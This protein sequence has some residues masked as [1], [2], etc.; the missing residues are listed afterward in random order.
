M[1]PH[2]V[3]E[4][5]TELSLEARRNT[6]S[7]R[8]SDQFAAHEGNHMLRLRKFVPWLCGVLA[9]ASLSPAVSTAVYNRIGRSKDSQVPESASVTNTKQTKTDQPNGDYGKLPIYFEPNVGQTDSEV[10]FIVRSSG[11]TTFLTATEA[12][13]S[14][15]VAK[16]RFPIQGGDDEQ[17]GSDMDFGLKAFDPAKLRRM[18]AGQNPQS[19]VASRQSA[20]TMRLVGANRNAQIEG[21][22]RLPG[23]SNYFIGNDPKS[24][25]TNIPHFAKVRYRDVYPGIDLVYYGSGRS[26]EYDLVVEPGGDPKRIELAFEGADEIQLAADGSLLVRVA[27]TKFLQRPP[28]IY[29]LGGKAQMGSS[30]AQRQTNVAGHYVIRDKR[31]IGFE[32]SSYDV[33][34]SLIIDPVIVYSSFLGGSQDEYA[35]G[36]AVDSTGNAYVTGYSSSADFPV[37]PGALQPQRAGNVDAFVGKVNRKGDAL[38]FMTYLGGSSGDYAR[39]MAL[40]AAGNLCLTG[41]AE[42]NNFP[43]TSNA[44]QRTLSGGECVRGNPCSDV[45]VAKLNPDGSSLHYSTYFGGSGDDLAYAIVVEP[46][47]ILTIAGTTS[48][49]VGITGQ[50]FP[51]TVGAYQTN[52]RGELDAFLARFSP[53]GS[54]LVYS[55]LFGGTGSEYAFALATDEV[56]NSYVAGMTS[57]RDLPTTPGA[58]QSSHA[59]PAGEPGGG[60][61]AFVAKLSSNGTALVYSTYLGGIREDAGQSIVVDSLGNAYVGGVTGSPNFPVSS[62]AFQRQYLGS[63]DGFLSK[64]N[65]SG[66]SLVLSTLLGGSNF[67]TIGAIALDPSGRIVATGRSVSVDFP[68]ETVPF[69]QYPGGSFVALLNSVGDQLL[70]SISLG[71][72]LE[73][74]GG[75]IAVHPSGDIYVA[76]RT[77]SVDFPTV[78][79]FQPRPGPAGSG[80]GGDA[81][82]AKVSFNTDLPERLFVPIVLGTSGANGSYFTSELALTNRA[83]QEA[84][85]EFTYTAAIGSGSGTGSDILPRGRQ[86]IVPDALAYLRALGIP[87][88]VS[89]N[90]GGTLSVLIR[91]VP[92]ADLG[93]VVRTT[94]ATGSGRAGLAYGGVSLSQALWGPSYLVGLRQDSQ[95]RSNVAMQNMGDATDGE[96]TLR[97]TVFGTK[98]SGGS[99]VL[100]DVQL[101]PGEFRQFNSILASSG[102]ALQEGYVRVDRLTG[103]APYYAYGV[104]NDQVTSDGSFV[105]PIRADAVSGFT[106]LAVVPA[107]V[108]SG[109]YVSELILTNTSMD[110]RNVTLVNMSDAIRPVGQIA[111]VEVPLQAGE[112]RIIRNYVQWLREQQ[113]LNATVGSPYAG[114]LNITANFPP[115]LSGVFAAVRVSTKGSGRFGVFY[116][117]VPPGLFTQRDAW[118]YGLQQNSTSRSNLALVNVGSEFP[119]K[120][121]LFDGETGVKVAT[122]GSIAPS[123]WL[124]LNGILAQYAPGVT[125]GYARVSRL[126]GFGPFITYA[127]INDGAAPGERTSDG[128]FISSSP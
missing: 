74:S 6:N 19:P 94:T 112:Q 18:P 108:E 60:Q 10:K 56:G 64:L 69:G 36:L 126:E 20:I 17:T 39:G 48:P 83:S 110:L 104:I 68:L 72:G 76:G 84:R 95:D 123:A 13:F 34:Q 101:S 103:T 58:V 122:V 90:Q 45:F 50:P 96:I 109:L 127:V 73:D 16:G 105:N 7:L 37:T 100:P 2:P 42:S 4:Q 28:R 77:V 3:S 113:P 117:S 63:G 125:Q 24:W 78:Y 38:L 66:T 55:S 88:P 53:N 15:P 119:Y 41:W 118:L 120:I 111:S 61:D 11:A 67:D 30:A 115:G 32:L 86:K 70:S 93:A 102:V 91:G 85:L 81:F 80:S 92:L 51:V 79:P 97:I 106:G 89:G 121:E 116:P 22:D 65:P 49:L 8:I 33:S 62:G 82:I 27:E 59:G 14:L 9:L 54:S 5:A 71:G 40:D 29:Q 75:A 43:A 23:I 21:V 44:Y 52:L 31:R 99:T 25:H 46:S 47:G 87:I 124:Q 98:P 12:V 1:A 57:S 35:Q 107:V 128:A 114:V 26:L